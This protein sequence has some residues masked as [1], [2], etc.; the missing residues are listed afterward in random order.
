MYI[1]LRVK[2]EYL[3]GLAYQYI[4]FLL[5]EI[6]SASVFYKQDNLED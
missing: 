5:L 6:H 1:F 3:P 2:F 4:G